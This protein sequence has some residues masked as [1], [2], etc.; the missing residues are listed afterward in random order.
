MGSLPMQAQPELG[1]PSDPGKCFAKAFIPDVYQYDYETYYRYTGHVSGSIAGVEKY[2]VETTAEQTKWVKKRADKNC[3]SS[4]PEDCMV[5]CLIT[6][7]PKEVEIME[8]VDTFLCKDFVL[9]S[10]K[11]ETI[12]QEGGFT[13][14]RQVVCE[15][16]I[17]QELIEEIQESLIEHGILVR[18]ESETGKRDK[19][20]ESAVVKIQRMNGLSIC[21]LDLETLDHLEIDW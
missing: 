14:W 2:F 3:L 15:R 18:G 1:M 16:Y 12:I 4:N 9:D 7:P 6:D 21:Q 5:W 11:Y 20:F 19:A 17:T 13:E 8:V 10:I